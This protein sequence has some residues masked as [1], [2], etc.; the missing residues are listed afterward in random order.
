MRLFFDAS[1]INQNKGL[2]IFDVFLFKTPLFFNVGLIFMTKSLLH[3]ILNSIFLNSK[4]HK[5]VHNEK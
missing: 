3:L 2:Y 1:K 5:Y 4:I